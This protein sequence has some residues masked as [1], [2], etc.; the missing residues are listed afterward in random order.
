MMKAMISEFIVPESGEE[1]RLWKERA[2]LEVQIDK[3]E[4]MIGNTRARLKATF[5]VQGRQELENEAD[6]MKRE[7]D[8][9][10]EEITT[11][12]RE[13]RAV[14]KEMSREAEEAPTKES[15]ARQREECFR[16]LAQTR[17]K[18][19]ADART[20]TELEG[21]LREMGGV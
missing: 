6:E 12:D 8:E 1:K 5:G 15:K 11:V 13:I 19:E 18:M 3:K 20:I 4:K 2:L 7:I 14:E 16:M 10:R 9:L 21:K 17:M